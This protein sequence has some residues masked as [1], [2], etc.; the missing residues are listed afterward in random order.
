MDRVALT[1]LLLFSSS[2]WAVGSWTTES[3]KA[4]PGTVFERTPTMQ[5][6]TF[7]FPS[8]SPYAGNG[9]Q[10][11][12]EVSAYGNPAVAGA[13]TGLHTAG[14][15]TSYASKIL[16][17]IGAAGQKAA[18]ILKSAIT[19]ANMAAAAL[20]LLRASI[21]I[22]I[23]SALGS[24]LYDSGLRY[25]SGE[26]DGVKVFNPAGGEAYFTSGSLQE[27]V[28]THPCNSGL[29]SC[30][31]QTATMYSKDMG[32]VI[33]IGWKVYRPP[34]SC[35]QGYAVPSGATLYWSCYNVSKSAPP[36]PLSVNEGTYSAPSDADILNRLQN[37]PSNPEGVVRDQIG[38]GNPPEGSTPSKGEGPSSVDG[39]KKTEFHPDG[40]RTET[41]TTY[42]ITYNDNRVDITQT[43]VHQRYDANGDPDGP[44]LTDTHPPDTPPELNQP[45]IN[46]PDLCQLHPEALACQQLGSYSPPSESLPSHNVNVSITPVEMPA[47]ECPDDMEASVMGFPITLSW[48]PLCT[49]A[50]GVKPVVLACA[51]LA[52]A[53]IV[54]TSRRG[55][56]T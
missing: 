8:D 41:T 18:V 40:S 56:E 38:H 22:A 35:W 28:A 33:E 32:T 29:G 1:L 30:A 20:G 44:P 54:F 15:V 31:G 9:F 36:A 55:T 4:G 5:T 53:Y 17:P 25:F 19:P 48:Q 42:N 34:N 11:S 50:M 27:Y 46:V 24:W 14:G 26:P 49:F 47:G 3:I 10:R 51:W 16:T 7:G 23:G 2:S 12:I 37:P 45:E 39:G 43:D 21:P 13:K 52:A 6:W